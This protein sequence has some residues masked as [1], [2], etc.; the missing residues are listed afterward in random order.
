MNNNKQQ[1]IK[2]K[3]CFISLMTRKEQKKDTVSVFETEVTNLLNLV[4]VSLSAT[5]IN[6]CQTTRCHKL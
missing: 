6:T 4:T 2:E 5:A 3:Y 1:L